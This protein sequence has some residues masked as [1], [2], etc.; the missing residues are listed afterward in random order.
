MNIE[1]LLLENKKLHE[2]ILELEKRSIV[3]KYEAIHLENIIST[4]VKRQ[5]TISKKISKRNKVGWL[6]LN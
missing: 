4:L 2:E 6:Y 5:K 3:L 1:E